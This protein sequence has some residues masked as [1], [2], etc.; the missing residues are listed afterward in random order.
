MRYSNPF[1]SPVARRAFLL[2]GI[3]APLAFILAACAEPQVSDSSPT[4]SLQQGRLSPT[5]A[6][7]D[8][9]KD[10]ITVPQTEGPYFKP[11]S[12]LR[13]LLRE[14]DL[15][16]VPLLV[17]GRVVTV[18]GQPIPNALL[19]FWHADAQ[20]VYD[21]VGF[22]LRGHQYTDSQGQ[23]FLETIVPGLYGPRT[24]H[25]HVK[26]QVPHQSILTTQR[27]FPGEARNT[28]DGLFNPKLLL[29]VQESANGKVA[30]FQF[31][32]SL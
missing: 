16:G 15:E 25:I 17:K 31:V 29:K 14:P 26:V 1:W 18:T 7:S 9:G 8:G 22:K 5:P 19:D 11:A 21:N 4:S 27:Y 3:T 32:M 24:S 20:G 12:P 13:T 23:Y 2:R 10:E 30:T 28:T 6:S